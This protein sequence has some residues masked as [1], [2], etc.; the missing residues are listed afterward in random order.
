MFERFSN[1][2]R[3]A[4]VDAQLV[5]RQQGTRSIDARHLLVALAEAGGPAAARLVSAT[6]SSQ[7]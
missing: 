2:A 3:A 6:A 4:V 5:A 1:E 7:G